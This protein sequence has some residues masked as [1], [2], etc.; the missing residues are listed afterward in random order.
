MKI[1]PRHPEGA[2][3]PVR[4]LWRRVF[5]RPNTRSGWW[6]VGL[7]VG[8]LVFFSLFLTLVASGQRGGETFVSNPWLAWSILPA[9]GSAIAAGMMATVAIFWRRERS[10]FSFIALFLGLLVLVFVFGE[11]EF[12]H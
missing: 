9:V 12:A 7:M 1:D 2:P 5:G 6:S 3:P 8:F 10:I 11:I 4:P